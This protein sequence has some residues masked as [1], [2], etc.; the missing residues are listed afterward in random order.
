MSISSLT[1][2]SFV[3]TTSSE[4]LWNIWNATGG[5]NLPIYTEVRFANYNSATPPQ[6]G[7][8]TCLNN[9]VVVATIAIAFDGSNNITSIS[10]TI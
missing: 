5:F 6:P 1:F 7:L 3:D 2:P 8:I 10:R 4:Q 9:G